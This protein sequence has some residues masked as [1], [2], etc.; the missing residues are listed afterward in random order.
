MGFGLIVYAVLALGIL[1]TLAGIGYSIRKAGADAV[2]AEWNAANL[3]AQE[4]QAAREMA[5][6]LIARKAAGEL[7][8]A[9]QKGAEYAAKWRKARA[10]AQ[11]PLASCHTAPPSDAAHPVATMPSTPADT[12]RLRFSWEFV[13]LFDTAWTGK[14]SEPVFGNTGIPPSGASITDSSPYGAEEVID[15][16][17]I[18]AQRC[19]EDRRNY[20]A[21]VKLIRKLQKQ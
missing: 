2:L 12:L 15:A 4:E 17:G 20:A 16:H 13:R 8:A 14:D 19:S 7:A 1:G 9:Q 10:E 18:N 11:K 5:A 21:L 3:K 6:A